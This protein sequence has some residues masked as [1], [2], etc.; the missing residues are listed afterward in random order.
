MTADSPPSRPRSWSPRSLLG[1]S[2][3][4]VVGIIGSEGAVFVRLNGRRVADHCY[5]PM[6]DPDGAAAVRELLAQDRKAPVTLLIDVLEQ[7]YRETSLPKL[8]WFDRRKMLKRKLAQT[9]GDGYLTSYLPLDRRTAGESA[10][11]G[12]GGGQA[13]RYVL[14][15]VP[16]S[17][18]MNAWMD[19]VWGAGNPLSAVALL[20]VEGTELVRRLAAGDADKPAGA[21]AWQILITRQRAGGFRQII[22]HNGQLVFTRLTPNLE[23]DSPVEEIVENIEAEFRSTLS[24]LR[25]LSFSDADRL[26]LTI[27]DSPEVCEGIQPRRMRIPEARTMTPA[28]ATRELGLSIDEADIAETPFADLLIAA[29]FAERGRVRLRLHT[30]QLRRAQ[31]L[32]L[33]PRAAMAA[34]GATLL[35]GGLYAG[36]WY[37]DMRAK[38]ERLRTQKAV[39]ERLETR[40]AKLK[41]ELPDAG[42]DLDRFAVVVDAR[43]ALAAAT[44]RYDLMLSGLKAALPDDMIVTQLDLEPGS[45]RTNL[46]RLARST[47]PKGLARQG[48][49]AHRRARPSNGAATP[50]ANGAAR[51]RL[52]AA[53]RLLDPPDDRPTVLIRYD[54]LRRALQARLPDHRV[55]LAKSP[56]DERQGTRD[57]DGPRTIEGV[58]LVTEAP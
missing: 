8:N 26:Q 40:L 12:E 9:Y 6:P 30:P 14:I 18:E 3:R 2:G 48:Y 53:V 17:E 52:H 29:W 44:P 20:P 24:Y 42:A 27:V 28:E 55:E 37:F 38:E 36:N 15:G 45:D 13:Q 19:I 7:H 23:P 1:L 25:R 43:E 22:L 49:S 21:P 16:E 47:L 31:V 34:A 32:T 39:H 35:L 51:P 57:G 11:Q 10:R 56:F 46:L 41:G 4:R 50:A 5:A 33:A 58:M 54:R